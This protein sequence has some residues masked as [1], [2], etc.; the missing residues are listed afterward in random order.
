MTAGSLPIIQ[1]INQ[2]GE[3][4]NNQLDHLYETYPMSLNLSTLISTSNSIS[5]I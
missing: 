2:V 1:N 4:E 3:F 5:D